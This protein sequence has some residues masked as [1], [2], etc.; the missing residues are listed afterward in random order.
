MSSTY[1]S[2]REPHI[3]LIQRRLNLNVQSVG[4]FQAVRKRTTKSVDGCVSFSGR[5]IAT[6]CVGKAS[7]TTTKPRK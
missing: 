7:T 5:Q 2:K 1:E 4:F 6:F 3:I